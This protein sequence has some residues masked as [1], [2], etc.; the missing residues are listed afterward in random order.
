[1]RV[2]RYATRAAAEAAA[3]RLEAQGTATWVTEA[4]PR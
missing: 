2:G 3:K 1:V 4:E